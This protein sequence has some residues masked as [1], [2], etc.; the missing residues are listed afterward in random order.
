VLAGAY[1]VG[2]EIT[3]W[4]SVDLAHSPVKVYASGKLINEGSGE[5][6]GGHPILPLVWLAND[7]RKRGDGL[8]AGMLVSTKQHHRRLPRAAGRG[9]RRRVRDLRHRRGFVHDGG[10]PQTPPAQPVSMGETQ[11]VTR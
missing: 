5:H 9:G 2:P 3:G 4:R 10:D 1:V 8:H 6:T 11:P 7:R